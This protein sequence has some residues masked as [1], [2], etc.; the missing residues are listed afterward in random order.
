MTFSWRS[1]GY[2]I[3]KEQEFAKGPPKYH[4]LG[5][6]GVLLTGLG[7]FKQI[8]EH[9]ELPEVVLA[10]GD[11]MIMVLFLVLLSFSLYVT[12]KGKVWFRQ[13]HEGLLSGLWKLPWFL[14]STQFSLSQQVLDKFHSSSYLELVFFGRDHHMSMR[15]LWIQ[16]FKW[17]PFNHLSGL[18]L[19]E[20]TELDLMLPLY[21]P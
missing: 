17:R 16:L 18:I 12:P 14:S 21:P 11:I 13:W 2:C 7:I 5:W 4:G 8:T 20:G 19:W 3:C 10:R 1:H 6:I 9:T 15:F